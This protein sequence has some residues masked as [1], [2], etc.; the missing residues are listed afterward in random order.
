[1]IQQGTLTVLNR[2]TSFGTLG[3]GDAASCIILAHICC[4][5]GAPNSDKSTG[6]GSGGK[7]GPPGSTAAPGGNTVPGGIGGS[8]IRPGSTTDPGGNPT[9]GGSGGPG[10][11]DAGASVAWSTRR[12]GPDA[13]VGS[14]PPSA[15]LK[16]A[17]IARAVAPAE[18]TCATG[19]LMA[20]YCAPLLA[21]GWAP[22]TDLL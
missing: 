9:P 21:A 14:P 4:T 22:V 11:G 12:T 1:M 19:V 13:A 17:S 20:K 6:D 18:T 8:G 15:A 5:S 3:G 16:S 7:F 2:Q 10:D